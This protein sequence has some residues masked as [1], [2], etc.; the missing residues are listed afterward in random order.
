MRMRFSPKLLGTALATVALLIVLAASTAIAQTFTSLYSFAG[1]PDGA[2]PYGDVITDKTGTLY[3][4]SRFGGSSNAG[5]IYKLS[6]GTETVL[7]SFTGGAD[8]SEPFAGL[9][10]DKFGTL[11]GTTPYGG[12]GYGTVF[13]LSS[14]G[15]LT[16][17][18]TFTGGADGSQ[19]FAGLLMDTKGNLYGTA[20]YGG[21]TNSG[22]VYKVNIKSKKGT[23]LYSF[24]GGADGAGPL[25][26]R[27]LR[28]KAGNLYGTTVGGGAYGNGTVWELGA[29]SKET[30]LY[31]FCSVSGCADGTGV[32][33][34]SLAMDSKGNLYGS[35]EEGGG[36]GAG[37]VFKLNPKTGKE[38]VLYSFT[39]ST[40]GGFPSSGLV[41][42]S[43]GHLFG[44]TQVGGAGYGVVFEVTGTK[45]TVLHSFDN[46]DGA[47]PFTSPLL[48]SKGT[49]YGVTS[50]GGT[51]G[52]GT[53][54]SLKP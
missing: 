45:E 54:F 1:S 41:R 44:T 33:E 52:N 2:T 15:T 18:Y 4:T 42:D 43:K 27:L 13:A 12:S 3:G 28:D 48:D 40:D 23:V 8:G 36:A 35:T 29:K 17:L 50:Y 38:K 14:S 16:T 24:A 31:S 6:K 26:G 22:T 39:N 21:T 30:V 25:Y 9:V 20:E 47:S 49:L 46:A 11:Y 19:P 10:M 7:Y 53:I 32:F 34:Q 51:S 5:T 37:T